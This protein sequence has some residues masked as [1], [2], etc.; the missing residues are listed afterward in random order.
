MEKKAN[1]RYTVNLAYEVLL[2]ANR[3]RFYKLKLRLNHTFSDG[4][5]KKLL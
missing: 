1:I 4:T 3:L 2:S 5:V